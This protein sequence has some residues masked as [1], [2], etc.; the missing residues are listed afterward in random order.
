MRPR[1]FS[2]YVRNSRRAARLPGD[3][4]RVASAS[5][6]VACSPP[7][8]PTTP[9]C[10][11][12]PRPWPR[13]SL[14]RT[15]PRPPCGRARPGGTSPGSGPRGEV[16]LRQ[17]PQ[18]VGA[19][20]D[21]RPQPRV[22]V[23]HRPRQAAAPRRSPPPAGNAPGCDGPT[24]RPPRRPP[25]RWRPAPRASPPPYAPWSRPRTGRP[26][27]AEAGCRATAPAARPPGSASPPA[28]TPRRWPPQRRPL[29]S[30]WP[31]APRSRPPRCRAP[32]R[33]AARRQPADHLGQGPTDGVAQEAQAFVVR[34]ALVAAG[35]AAVAG[36]AEADGAEGG[37]GGALQGNRITQSL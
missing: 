8:P 34:V 32:A 11:P 31:D 24:V 14:R 37:Y 18:P 6:A 25:W 15:P 23:A 5:T 2:R 9:S 22:L 19:V 13:C 28:A 16:V 33:T 3:R 4:T 35:L 10:A 29:P 20:G 1:L 30:A 27:P 7:G 36:P 17:L 12:P 26:D 21:E